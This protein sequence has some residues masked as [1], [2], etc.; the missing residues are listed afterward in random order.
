MPNSVPDGP[1]PGRRATR[2]RSRPGGATGPTTFDNPMALVMPGCS[3]L[4]STLPGGA[5]VT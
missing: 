2:S 5:V 1:A 4:R 3:D